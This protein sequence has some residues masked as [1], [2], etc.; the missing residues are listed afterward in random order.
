MPSLG[1]RAVSSG[2]RLEHV[3]ETG[4]TSADLFLSAKDGAHGTIWRVA[5]V[6]TGGRGRRSRN[7]VSPPGNL[8]A[9]V[10]ISD[11]AEPAHVAELSFVLALALRDAVLKAAGLAD[12][13]RL[14]LKWPNDLMYDGRKTAGLL[15]EGGATGGGAFAV[16]GFGVNIRSH[17]DGTT[18][19]ATDLASAGYRLDRDSLFSALSDSVATRLDEWQRGANFDAV[20]RDWLACAHGLG[21]PIRVN[22]LNDSFDATFETVDVSGRLVV[23]TPEGTRTVSAGEVFV[24]EDTRIG[25]VQ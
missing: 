13:H 20:R 10:L 24:L 18:H 8:Y 22:A 25:D 12:D 7:W 19:P 4:S 14:R 16:A 23:S 1:P 2:A 21:K 11:P 3:A 9:S 17:P 5:D 15:L 6:Q